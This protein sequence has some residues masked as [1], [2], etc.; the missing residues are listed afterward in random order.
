MLFGWIALFMIRIA[1]T[2][3]LVPIK[4]ELG[5]SYAQAGILATAYFYAYTT[6]QVPAGYLGDK[7]GRKAILVL[8]SLLWS[9]TCFITSLSQTFVQIFLARLATGVAQGAYFGNDRPIVASSTPREKMTLGQSISFMGIGAGLTLGIILGGIIASSLNWRWVFVLFS[10]PPA[11]AALVFFKFIREPAR[12]D[13]YRVSYR[14]EFTKALRKR[15]LWTLYLGGIAGM[16]AFFVLA[17]WTTAVLLEVGVKDIGTAS[18]F[19]S[20]IGLAILPSLMLT[21]VITDRIVKTGKSRGGVIAAL[22]SVGAIFM[23]LSGWGIA[24]KTSIP[25][26]LTVIFFATF[27]VT[28][29]WGPL[30][31]QLSELARIEVLGITY[32][33]MNTLHFIGPMTAPWV[34]GLIRDYTGSFEWGFYVA[35]VFLLLSVPLVLKVRHAHTRVD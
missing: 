13:T 25:T 12:R 6:M 4:E 28:G 16:Y 32:G 33:I 18:L 10:I 34:T 35:A 23:V 5:L 27:C 19:S 9:I 31:A 8:T 1:I 30:Q 2:P 29:V 26:L 11:V 14:A 24:S 20:I 17:T 7:F 22:Y 15:N 3:T 21:G